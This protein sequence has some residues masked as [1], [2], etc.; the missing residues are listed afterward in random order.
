M[1]LT[2]HYSLTT[3]LTDT[4][5]IRALVE[6]LRSHAQDLPLQE[7]DE[8]IE[9]EGE[10]CLLDRKRQDDPHKW[11][12]IQAGKYLESGKRHYHVDP[13]HTIGFSTWPGEGCEPANFGFC[14]YPRSIPIPVECSRRRCER[15]GLNGWSWGSFCKTQ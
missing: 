8:L 1:G 12:K 11:F 9:L 10:D 6:T 13:E 14:R 2:I 4:S 3:K 5:S 7:V 15:T